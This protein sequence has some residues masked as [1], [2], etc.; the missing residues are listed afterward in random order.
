[1]SRGGLMLRHANDGVELDYIP[2]IGAV[3]HGSRA[4]EAAA[5]RAIVALRADRR[6]IAKAGQPRDGGPE[7]PPYVGPRS[8]L[9]IPHD[10]DNVLA[11]IEGKEVRLT[12]LRKIFWPELG[13]TKGDLFST[14][15]MSRRAA[16]AHPRP[17][18]GDEA[19]P[20]WARRATSSS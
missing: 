14:T 7:S 1:M 11:S 3:L 12:N 10:Q 20:A 4:A 8:R 15:P 17:R 2:V 6:R 5:A 18:D 16:A 13:L 19:V 9:I